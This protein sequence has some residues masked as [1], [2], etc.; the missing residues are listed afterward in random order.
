MQSIAGHLSKK[1]LDHHSHVRIMAKRQAVEALGGGGIA[2]D[3]L[4]SGKHTA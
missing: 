4:M 2:R 1:M 3:F